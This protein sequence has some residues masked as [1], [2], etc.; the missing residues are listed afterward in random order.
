[1]TTTTVVVQ[2][3]ST[4]ATLVTQ[5]NTIIAGGL[6]GP[7]GPASAINESSDVDASNL[8]DGSTLVYNTAAGKW[9]ASTLL[10]KQ[11]INAGF[12]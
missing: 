6:I 2:S 11:V 5:T 9:Q 10:E 7:R 1:M 4:V 3:S 12:F 8:K